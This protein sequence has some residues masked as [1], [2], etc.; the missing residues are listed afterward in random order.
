M[1]KKRTS[2]VVYNLDYLRTRALVK[3]DSMTAVTQ[4]MLCCSVIA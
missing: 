3:G 4:L 1:L 2:L